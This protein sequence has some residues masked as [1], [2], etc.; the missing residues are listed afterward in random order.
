M[1]SKFQSAEEVVHPIT[2][3]NEAETYSERRQ[4]QQQQQQQ[5]TLVLYYTTKETSALGYSSIPQSQLNL[6]LP[7]KVLFTIS[8]SS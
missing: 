8:Q 3:K 4:Q 5:H 2:G 1:T 7:E 6:F